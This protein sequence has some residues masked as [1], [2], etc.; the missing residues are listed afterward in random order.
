MHSKR[1]DVDRST[2][3]KRLQVSTLLRPNDF[4]IETFSFEETLL[5]RDHNLRP[6]LRITICADLEGCYLEGVGGM[7]GQ[8][9]CA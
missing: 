2:G 9:R 3:H 7:R 4:Q 6:K 1:G 8:R 5:Y